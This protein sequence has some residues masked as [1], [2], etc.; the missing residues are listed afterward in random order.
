MHKKLPD[1]DD[2]DDNEKHDEDGAG[3]DVPVPQEEEEEEDFGDYSSGNDQPPAKWIK[4]SRLSANDQ[5]AQMG[6]GLSLNLDTD[7]M[8]RSMSFLSWSSHSSSVMDVASSVDS[9]I[10]IS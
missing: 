6:R 8:S 4:M 9:D 10:S 2:D 3:A 7:R 1:D 5:I